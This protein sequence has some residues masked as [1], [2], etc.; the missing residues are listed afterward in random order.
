MNLKHYKG[1]S[2]VDFEFEMLDDDGDALD[3]SIYSEIY[4]KVYTKRGGTE[5]SS[6]D[7]T[8][9]LSVFDN[10]ITWNAA[11]NWTDDYHIGLTYFHHCYGV[12]SEFLSPA[13][14]NAGEEDVL[15]YNNSEVV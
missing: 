3:L 7:L 8:D 13:N 4:L 11:K 6:F 5:L 1:K 12:I 14:A 10:V 9:G 2:I 15:F